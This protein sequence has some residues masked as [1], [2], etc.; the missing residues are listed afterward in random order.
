MGLFLYSS[1]GTPL[2]IRD[3][4]IVEISSPFDHRVS[5]YELSSF[6]VFLPSITHCFKLCV[7]LCTCCGGGRSQLLLPGEREWV[8]LDEQTDANIMLTFSRPTWREIKRNDMRAKAVEFAQRL[9]EEIENS[10]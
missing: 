8:H 7:R 1:F 6:I 2:T 9:V 5:S 10:E 4:F 3:S